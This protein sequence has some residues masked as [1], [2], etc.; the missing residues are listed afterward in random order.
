VALVAAW[1]HPGSAE[2]AAG[3]LALVIV[4]FEGCRLVAVQVCRRCGRCDSVMV[5]ILD[6]VAHLMPYLAAEVWQRRS[7][8]GGCSLLLPYLFSKFS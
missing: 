7:P 1:I 3:V 5:G 8:V 2:D 4:R 6:D